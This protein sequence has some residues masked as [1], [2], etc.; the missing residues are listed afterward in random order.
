[1]LLTTM[2]NSPA[3]SGIRDNHYRGAAAYFLKAMIFSN[4]KLGLFSQDR[5]FAS[6]V[7]VECISSRDRSVSQ[8]ILI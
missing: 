8:E 7:D 4:F 6:S 1:M 3:N 2:P 5:P